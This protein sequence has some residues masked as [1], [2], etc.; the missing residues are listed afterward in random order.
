[1]LVLFS[2]FDFDAY[3]W[4]RMAAVFMLPWI[5]VVCPTGIDIKDRV[6]QT[7]ASSSEK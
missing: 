7:D 2:W 3:R 6:N 1:M 5:L 4:H